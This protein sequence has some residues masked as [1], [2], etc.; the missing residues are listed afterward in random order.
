MLLQNLLALSL[1]IT[2]IDLSSC[3]YCTK[4][5]NKG[6]EKYCCPG[7]TLQ[8]N[9]CEP[10]CWPNCPAYSRCTNVNECTCDA[11]Y[12]SSTDDPKTIVCQPQCTAGCRPHSTC[13][14][15]ETCTCDSGYTEGWNG[16]CT[17]TSMTTIAATVISSTT[18]SIERFN[19]TVEVEVLT[20][21]STGDENGA[22]LQP[23]DLYKCADACSCWKVHPTEECLEICE[24]RETR[25]LEPQ[26]SRCIE[27]S[28]RIEYKVSG[29]SKIYTC[30]MDSSADSMKT[31]DGARRL[32]T[33]VG[34][35]FTAVMSV[36][37]V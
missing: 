21:A 7:Y 17:P 2:V 1:L 12:D 34:L 5:T 15:P 10:V 25:C 8:N 31:G 11:G 16:T 37:F 9:T 3:Q 20:E 30:Y 36:V 6:K 27:P 29:V 24:S 32:R 33:M 14:Q 13:T 26:F 4:S 23:N 22:L 28:K 35:L 18:E 19:D